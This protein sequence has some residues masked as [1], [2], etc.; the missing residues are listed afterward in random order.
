MPIPYTE[1]DRRLLNAATTITVGN[2]EM[3]RFWES[4]WLQGLAPKQ[5]ASSIYAISKKKRRTVANAT[6]NDVWVHDIDIW[7]IRSASQIHEFI[8]LWE[9]LRGLQLSPELPDSIVWKYTKHGEYTAA[10]AYEAQFTWVAS[11]P[12]EH[13]IWRVWAPPKCKFFSWLAFQNRLWTADRLMKRRRQNQQVCMLCHSND[14]T[15][16]HMFTQCQYSLSVWQNIFNWVTPHLPSRTD[17]SAFTSLQEWWTT[18][19]TMHP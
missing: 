10:S 3:A 4:A 9:R 5:I 18:I 16:L 13:L 14:E 6:L 8:T 1:E 17:W 7:H 12:M 19:G 11:S 15:G 2:G